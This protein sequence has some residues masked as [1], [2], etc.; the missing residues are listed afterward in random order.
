M[1]VLNLLVVVGVVGISWVGAGLSVIEGS[2]VVVSLLTVGR[3]IV[4]RSR[5]VGRSRSTV[6]RRRSVGRS[7]S[8]VSVI[9]S[10]TSVDW[11]PVSVSSTIWSVILLLLLDLVLDV[12]NLSL[13]FFRK[14]GDMEFK[15]LS[16]LNHGFKTGGVSISGG[17]SLMVGEVCDFK[18]LLCQCVINLCFNVMRLVFGF[19]NLVGL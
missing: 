18:F 2:A 14:V 19:L 17:L 9:A 8:V 5:F 10:L 12:Q 3:S 7:R 13:D 15:V 1:E 4:G 16:F 11:C 6:G